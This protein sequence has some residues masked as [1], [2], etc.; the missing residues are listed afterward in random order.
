MTATA[1]DPTPSRFARWLILETGE[2]AGRRKDHAGIVKEFITRGT[3]R[4]RLAYA[5]RVVD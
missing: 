5:S 2:M 3:A 1:P 4:H